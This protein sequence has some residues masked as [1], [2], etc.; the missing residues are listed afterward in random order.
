MTLKGRFLVFC[1]QSSTYETINIR[2]F[3]FSFETILEFI[4]SWACNH[5]WAKQIL[6]KLIPCFLVYILLVFSRCEKT[7]FG[8][9]PFPSAAQPGPRQVSWFWSC[10]D[11]L[12]YSEMLSWNVSQQE[13]V[14]NIVHSLDFKTARSVSLE[15]RVILITMFGIISWKWTCK[16]LVGFYKRL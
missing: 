1:P 15:E 4:I 13:M 9:P 6:D 14:W 2:C 7:M 8:S 5:W 12:M 10:A 16:P 11:I 3:Q